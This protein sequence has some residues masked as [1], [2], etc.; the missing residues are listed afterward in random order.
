[1]RFL[2]ALLAAALIVSVAVGVYVV[3]RLTSPG[4]QTLGSGGVWIAAAGDI[5]CPP[6]SPTKPGQCRQQETSDLIAGS[7]RNVVAVLALGDLQYEHAGLSE[8][9]HSYAPTWGRF[10]RIVHPI[11]GNHEYTEPGASGY[12]DYFEATA[13]PPGKGWY[14]FELSQAPGWHFIAL[15]ANCG[16]IGGCGPGS[17]ELRW[18]LED[19]R[20]H[21]SSAYPCTLAYWHQPRFSSSGTSPGSETYAAFWQALQ[22]AGADIVLNGHSHVYER[23]APQDSDGNADPTGPRE[24]IVGT[25]GRSLYAFAAPQPNSQVRI[26]E[27]GVLMLRLDRGGYTWEFDTLG[28]P[29]IGDTGTS[30]CS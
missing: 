21:P 22:D 12:F 15:N 27:F 1:V 16:E 29:G 4:S 30:A 18:L 26:R 3:R 7:P 6:G 5:A 19:L 25:G 17:P 24:F 2:R 20:A 10:D 13:G 9:Q 11:P 8:F 23:F 14:S 28:S